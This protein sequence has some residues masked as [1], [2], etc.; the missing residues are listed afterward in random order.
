MR[1]A[2]ARHPYAFILHALGLALLMLVYGRWQV[3]LAWS[4]PAY[5]ILALWPWLGP[6][7]MPEEPAPLIDP[8]ADARLE[9]ERRLEQDAAERRQLEAELADAHARLHTHRQHAQALLDEAAEAQPLPHAE[10]LD[11][12]TRQVREAVEQ[13]R[14][15]LDAAQQRLTAQLARSGEGRQRV[16]ALA[17]RSEAIQQVAQSIQS[18]AS[19]T[20]LLALNAAIEAAR[21]GDAGR[22]FAVVADEVR[23]LAARTAQATE[24]VGRMAEDIRQQTAAAVEHLASQDQGLVDG[25]AALA[26]LGETLQRLDRD[27]QAVGEVLAPLQAEWSACHARQQARCDASAEWARQG[28]VQ[29]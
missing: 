7:K 14:A 2:Y 4:V 10:G 26:P 13:G 21:A 19:Q 27:S 16:E 20:N 6:W 22:G 28:L 23:N 3:P 1:P 11:A 18:I 12:A 17:T 15:T 29:G 9:R 8:A 24:E 25:V 5:L